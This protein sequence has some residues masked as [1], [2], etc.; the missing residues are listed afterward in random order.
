MDADALL[1]VPDADLTC[2]LLVQSS[3]HIQIVLQLGI[4]VEIDAHQDVT[5]RCEGQG[6]H[7]VRV[8]DQ[9]D[10]GIA[11]QVVHDDHAAS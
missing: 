9:V 4:A 2:W 1:P 10:L 5:I 8:A 11:H 3:L 7:V 6:E